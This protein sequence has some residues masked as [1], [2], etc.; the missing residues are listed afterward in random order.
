MKTGSTNKR[1]QIREPVRLPLNTTLKKAT[2]SNFST[3][4]G[5]RNLSPPLSPQQQRVNIRRRV[6]T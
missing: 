5:K 1:V 2:S 3:K 4:R 6:A